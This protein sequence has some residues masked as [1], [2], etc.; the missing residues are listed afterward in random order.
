MR[1]VAKIHTLG[2]ETNGDT[3][4]P[5]EVLEERMLATCEKRR[6]SATA[7]LFYVKRVT[8]VLTLVWVLPLVTLAQ[9]VGTDQYL[10][11]PVGELV[12]VGD[13]RVSFY[14][15]GPGRNTVLHMVATS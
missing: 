6:L 12:D 14:C 1:T 15:N 7:K 11:T 10:P 3:I 4:L 9:T 13:Y 5:M 8:I 2:N